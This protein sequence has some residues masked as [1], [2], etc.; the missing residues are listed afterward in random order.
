VDEFKDQSFDLVITVCD[1]AKEN[2]PVLPGQHQKLH[3][4]FDDPAH[5]DG[6]EDQILAEFSRVR[7]EIQARFERELA[8]QISMPTRSM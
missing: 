2:C 5:V 7:D 6:S 3:W 1:N 4:P 8:P